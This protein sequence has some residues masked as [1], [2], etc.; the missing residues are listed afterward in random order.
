MEQVALSAWPRQ[1][2]GKGAPGR[3]RK[4]GFIPAVI[5][6]PD[7]K[8][9]LLVKLKDIEVEKLLKKYAGKNVLVNLNIYGAKERIVMFKDMDR[10]P[11][12]EK[13]E[14]LDMLNVAM[15]RKI[16]VAVRVN[17]TGKAAGVA[18]GGILHQEMRAIH[19]ECLPK[20]IPDAIDVDVT[21][22]TIGQSL[23]IG[24]IKVPAGAK[25]LDDK[26]ST[27]VLVSVPMSE[28]A[29][30]KT[31]EEAKAEIAKSFEVPE[32]EKAAAEAGKEAAPA[33]EAS[34]EKKK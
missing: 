34:K 2:E 26:G 12:T 18:E 13:I 32:D 24:D 10:H 5:Y 33:K 17:I 9:N 19:I 22:L 8:E 31:A 28:V 6:G 1:N 29:P 20:D 14:H 4:E 25:V 21:S 11:L 27:V 16:A 30:V 3:L 15:D 23:H 7:M